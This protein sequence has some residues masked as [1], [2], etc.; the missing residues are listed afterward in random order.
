MEI[1][2]AHTHMRMSSPPHSTLKI[3]LKNPRAPQNIVC[4]RKADFS[5]FWEV[6]MVPCG[7]LDSEDLYVSLSSPLLNRGLWGYDLSSPILNS[8]MCEAGTAILLALGTSDLL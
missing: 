3:T 6:D 8:F 7:G 2:S 5:M 4:Y 1:G